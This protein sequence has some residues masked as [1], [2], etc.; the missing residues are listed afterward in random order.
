MKNIFVMTLLSIMTA[1]A[2]ER[3]SP[4]AFT[5]SNLP[6]VII[7]THGQSIPDEP[8]I[9]ADMGIIFNGAGKRNNL[10]DSLNLYNGKIGI[11]I[12][13]SS[14]QMFPKKQYGLET[15][16][17]LGGEL[18]VSFFGMPLESDWI[19]SAPYN[20]KSLMR[21]ALTY[22]LSNS[23]GR[24]A[25]RT[26]YCELVLN[27]EYMGVYILMEKLKRDKGRVNIS[28]VDTAAVSGDGLSGGYII[29]I[30]KLSGSG[31]DGWIS[32]YPPRPGSPFK[33]NY[34]YEYPKMEEITAAERAYIISFFYNFESV[35]STSAYAD[36]VNGY[37]K[38]LDRSSMVDFFLVNE[39]GRNVDGFRLSS[40]MYKDKDS[41]NPKMFLGPVWD[42]NHAYGN[43]D[44]YDA[45]NISGWQL[46]W[47]NTN[48]AFQTGDMWQPPFW[49][50]KVIEDS[51]F[52][53]SADLRWRS[54]RKNQL[55]VARINSFIDSVALHVDEA[56]Q[57]NFVR[58]PIL[59]QY[60]WPNAYIG[61]TYANEI[62]YLKNWISQRLVWMDWKLT[63]GPLA[64]VSGETRQPQQFGLVQNYPNPFNP[65]TTI[66]YSLGTQEH[67]TL[68]VHDILGKQIAVLVDGQQDAGVHR[69]Q[70]NSSSFSLSRRN[71][72]GL[73]SGIYFYQLRAGNFYAQQKMVI[74]K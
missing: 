57:R 44:Y 74:L 1:F 67:V 32:N 69:V 31:N 23:I 39:L 68:T 21:D 55:S 24:Y 49:W 27:G 60:V 12:R 51:L 33:I 10:T 72:G 48:T 15:R 7:N 19:L 54:L 34:L 40:F 13:G 64:A 66:E 58:W 73:A 9:T 6:I 29:K 17:S 71:A 16:D 45:S 50:F 35:F 14:S 8:K 22:S 70:F 42:F 20:D 37:A 52:L 2:G 5:S 56:Q 62:K 47:F 46:N 59:N 26:R 43:S 65:S 28:K 61:G 11:E 38:Y 41:K 63:G 36:T 18:D 4:A 30:D 25:S 53:Q 3:T